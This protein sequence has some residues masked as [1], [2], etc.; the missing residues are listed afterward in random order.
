MERVEDRMEKSKNNNAAAL[1]PIFNAVKCTPSI[2]SNRWRSQ[3]D[4]ASEIFP[5]AAGFLRISDYLLNSRDFLHVP[6]DIASSR[7]SAGSHLPQREALL[8]LSVFCK[9]PDILQR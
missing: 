9:I 7:S 8:A 3:G 1:R 4:F 2:C 6:S 5:F